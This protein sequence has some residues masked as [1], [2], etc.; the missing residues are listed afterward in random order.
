[1]MHQTDKFHNIFMVILERGILDDVIYH[2][3]SDSI[4]DV[5]QLVWSLSLPSWLA[6]S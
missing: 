2:Y 3:G 1:M 5:S 6:F 4:Q